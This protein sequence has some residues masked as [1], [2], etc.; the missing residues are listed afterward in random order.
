MGG[1]RSAGTLDILFSEGRLTFRWSE[2]EQRQLEAHGYKKDAE[3]GKRYAAIVAALDLNEDLRFPMLD[4]AIPPPPAE[5]PV[6]NGIE[7]AIGPEPEGPPS[8]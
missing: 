8:Y 7:D 3:R 5:L 2:D 1:I 6:W 4:V